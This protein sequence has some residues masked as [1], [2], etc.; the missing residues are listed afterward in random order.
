MIKTTC[1]PSY[2]KHGQSGQAIVTLPD[3]LGRRR[4]IL[5]GKYGTG[6]SRQEYARVIAEW[7]AN[8][9]RLLG[10]VA[11]A[12]P[13]VNE[14]MLTYWKFAEEYYRKNGKP[15]SQQD[16]IR[17]AFRPVKQ[18]YGHTAAKNFGPLALKAVR[19]W[20]VQQHWTRG[21]VN[22]SVGCIKRMF[23]WGVENELVHPSIY[24]GLQAVTGLKKGR[25]EARETKPIRP[26]ADEHVDAVLP[27][28]NPAQRAMVQ[29][30]RFTGMRPGEVC[31]MRPCD[32]DRSN[33]RTWIYRPESHKTEHHDIERVV[34][35]GPRAQEI[36]KPFLFRDPGVYCFSP[37]EMMERHWLELRSRRKTKV[38][39]SQ[40]CR[41]RRRPKRLPGEHYTVGSYEHAISQAC[42]KANRK[43]K[44]G[45]ND[46]RNLPAIIPHWHPNQLRHTKATE[47]RRE[48]GLDAAR[49]V[50]GHRSPQVTEIY[51]EIDVNK[52]VEIMGKLG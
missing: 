31:I 25:S 38:Q 33:P 41:K 29:L 32:L 34:F 24:H 44:E 5:L 30:Q 19:E 11:Q 26:V 4:D 47:I 40:L 12:N 16:R 1:V 10:P 20:M 49:V 36:V 50:L 51:A 43:P 27:F 23:K 22:S 48:A 7:E 3:G 28:L 37:R 9:R 14:L 15:T 6:E 42:T 21:Y 35:L 8:G 17:L 52:A 18:M 2:R 13:T 45:N 46:T 39:P